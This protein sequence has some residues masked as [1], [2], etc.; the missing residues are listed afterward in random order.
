MPS[1][2]DEA[3]NTP[4][5]LESAQP[6]SVTHSFASAADGDAAAFFVP[7]PEPWPVAPEPTQRRPT[8]LEAFALRMSEWNHRR[9]ARRRARRHQDARAQQQTYRSWIDEYDTLT[10]TIIES[11][12]LRYRDLERRPLISVVMPVFNPR[13][14]QLMAAVHSVQAQIYRDWE[15]CIADDA[16]THRDVRYWLSEL[17]RRDPRVKLVFRASNGHI[18]EA[19]NSAL[20]L[21]SGEY[22]A[23]LDQDDLLRPHSL[24]VAAEAM[25]AFPDA[26]VLYSDEDKIDADGQR[27][28]HYF[29]CDWSPYLLRSH[30]ML[31]HLGIYQ[32]GLVA[33][34]GGF[35]KGFE[36]AQ[37]YDLALRCCERIS[38]R[39]IVHLPFV[40]YH[41][42]AHDNS[43][44]QGLGVKPYAQKAGERALQEHLDRTG[45]AGRAT[46]SAC[47]YRVRY[48]LPAPPPRVTLV[49]PTRDKVEVLRACI[50]SVLEETDY[51]NY[52]I[53][54]VDNGS[55]E[56]DALHYLAS[57]SDHPKI[58]VVSD[59]RPFNYSR[60]NNEAV[61]QCTADY[62]CLL[63]NDI[64]VLTPG[65]LAEMLSLAQQ[66]DVGAV[67]AKLLYPD[68]SLQ[69]G[70]VIVGIGGVA[71]HAHKNFKTHAPGYIGRARL[72][73]EF[74]A[75]TGACLLVKREAYLAVG[76]LDEKRL[77]VAFNDV[78]FCLKLK[79]H[80]Y[81]NI[82][83]PHA[84]LYHHESVSRGIDDDPKKQA[85]FGKEAD[86]MRYRWERIIRHDPS[87]SPNLSVHNEHFGL[88]FPPRVSLADPYW[89]KALARA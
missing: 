6:L 45:I 68:G 24:L 40:L 61:A 82:W 83:T 32:R 81:R 50:T 66:P 23:L 54:V 86:Y 20:E 10:P 87:Y 28:G 73:Q 7:L 57:L 15:L 75:V 1:P 44:A 29:K 8:V 41:W 89:F 63:N 70:G 39:Q 34:V 21:A 84:M 26:A 69:H 74:S 36:G 49:I 71:G 80:G 16:S 60:L 33:S 77:P 18:C 67:G 51:E 78:D 13:L 76:G 5:L 64:E 35:R 12:K 88:A 53:V 11:F 52:D 79:E 14:E 9:L 56:Q 72:I 37:D 55:H 85:R 59:P 47:G 30:N 62:V 38:P 31:S 4:A 42:R 65:W 17:E 22:V 46:V 27:T 3:M 19:S 2:E 25:N 43:T 58:S 48:A